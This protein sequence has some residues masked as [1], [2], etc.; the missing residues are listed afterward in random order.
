MREGRGAAGRFR[1]V[2]NGFVG[3]WPGDLGER[4]AL[5]IPASSVSE[6][7]LESAAG[8]AKTVSNSRPLVSSPPVLLAIR[9]ELKAAL[10]Q[11]N[12]ST[13]P[14]LQNNPSGLDD[15][16]LPGWGGHSS[17]RFR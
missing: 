2:I 8:G 13:L 14:A 16:N 7:R 5:W 12:W 11:Q 3:Q 4:P 15:L 1:R 10:S 6:A 9:P 17:W